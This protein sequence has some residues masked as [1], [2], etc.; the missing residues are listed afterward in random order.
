MTSCDLS[1][2]RVA[3]VKTNARQRK[4]ARATSQQTSLQPPPPPFA[5]QIVFMLGLRGHD[6]AQGLSIKDQ[7]VVYCTEL[8]VVFVSVIARF[9]SYRGDARLIIHRL[10]VRRTGD[11]SV[12]ISFAL[13]GIVVFIQTE[14]LRAT[15]LVDISLNARARTLKVS[16]AA[17]AATEC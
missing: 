9:L 11:V 13:F 2:A 4:K 12:G 5:L 6:G 3:G 16:G 10:W 15:V 8:A 7:R 17:I 14:V 1:L